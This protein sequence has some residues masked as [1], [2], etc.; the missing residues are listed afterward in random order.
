M[1]SECWVFVGQNEYEDKFGD[2]SFNSLFVASDTA[3]DD[4]SAVAE[5]LY[6]MDCVSSV[7]F[8]SSEREVFDNLT[9]TLTLVVLVLVICAGALVVIVL[10]NL[11]N[12]NIGERK[13]EIATLKVLGYKKREVSGYVFREIAI[14]V[15]LGIAVGIGLGWAILAFILGSIQAPYLTFPLVI[16]WWSYLVT[17]AATLLFSGLVD[18]I[19]LPKLN[20]IDMADSMK[21]VD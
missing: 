13:K 5:R 2:A 6:G 16:D 12:I 4:Q 11:T 18:L 21:A 14:L 3:E 19:L 20:K 7:T 1:Y 17:A 15:I 8:T 10:Y 9:E